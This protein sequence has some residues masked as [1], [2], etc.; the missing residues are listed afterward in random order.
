MADGKKTGGRRGAIPPE[1]NG[2]WIPPVPPVVSNY[3]RMA[4]Y[5]R[6]GLRQYAG[7][8]Y[9][10]YETKLQGRRGVEIYTEMA[11][12][13]SVIGAMLFAVE[14]LLRQADWSVDPG[15]DT[16][17]DEEAAEF[18]KS[19]MNDMSSTWQD[20]ISEIMT[21]I[22]YGWSWHEIVYKRRMGENADPK[23]HSKYDDGLIG[24]RKLPIRSQDT[25]WQW[26]FSE[27]GELVGMTQMAPPDFSV[28]TIP[29]S[30][31]ILFRTKSRK[32]SPEGRS[33]LRNCYRDWYF[34]R[35]MQEIEGIGVER[36]LAG[37]PMLT[38]P[39][40]V[41]I[42]D[43][44]D[45]MMAQQLAY[46]TQLVQNVRRDALEGIVIPFGWSFQLLNGGSRRQF[47]IGS[48]IE[49]Y[50]S[51]IAM[52]IL[53][54]FVLLG[55]QEAG[56]WA[57]SSD[58]TEMFAMAIGTYMEII[59][60]AFNTQAIP[61]LID[62]NKEHFKGIT[63]YPKMTHGD[64]EQDDAQKFGDL[65]ARLVGSGVITPSEELAKEVCRRVGLPEEVAAESVP[66]P[67]E[68]DAQGATQQ[69]AGTAEGG[70]EENTR[71]Q[72]EKAQNSQSGARAGTVRRDGS[73]KP[74]SEQLGQQMKKAWTEGA[75]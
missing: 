64:V 33:I 20:T 66:M 74:V 2:A 8:L 26:N 34:K 18:V 54:D 67:P 75:D 25:L 53:A 35:R 55:H 14:M 58:K 57:L 9:E 63:A 49:R 30:K 27:D 40:G 11:E 3:D 29:K 37:L 70:G 10:E 71:P 28:R 36:D 21:F 23:L 38:P 47:E 1:P 73:L 4:E 22:T 19:C 60:E 24:W 32:D 48:I 39:E 41:N 68:T 69:G 7:V 6:T 45:P 16:K 44:S 5:G 17:A 50:D 59:C 12:S 52:T 31:S 56:S 72:K 65:V 46:A 61:Q 15:G 51:R 62:L 42:W 43:Q 13:D